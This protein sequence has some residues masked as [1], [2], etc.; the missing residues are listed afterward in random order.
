MAADVAVFDPTTFSEQ[1]TV[2]EPNVLATGIRDLFVNGLATI[3]D[4]R[5]TGERAGRIVRG[6]DD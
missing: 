4:G 5:A 1:G 2:F 6:P 3:R